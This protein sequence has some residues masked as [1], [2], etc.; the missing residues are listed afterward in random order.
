VSYATIVLPSGDVRASELQEAKDAANEKLKELGL[1]LVGKP[2]IHKWNDHE[3]VLQW[4]VGR[5]R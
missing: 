4:D 3:M 5:I 1:G 2:V